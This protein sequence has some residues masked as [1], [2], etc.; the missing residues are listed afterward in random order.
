MDDVVGK[1]P[2]EH[3]M[4]DFENMKTSLY[5]TDVVVLRIAGDTI[6]FLWSWDHQDKQGL[7]GGK[8][9]RSLGIPFEPLRGRNRL[10]TQVKRY[11]E[12][13][14]ARDSNS[15]GWSCFLQLS[16]SRRKTHLPGT[17]ETRHATCHPS[18]IHTSLHSHNREQARSETVGTISR[19]HA[20]SSSRTTHDGSTRFDC[21]S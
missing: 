16:H 4:S 13:D 9:N 19:R 14:G 3:L 20:Q 17:L 6:N 1:G 10:P 15:S 2:E 12:S 11:A 5:L 21:W 7:R 18:T 8:Q